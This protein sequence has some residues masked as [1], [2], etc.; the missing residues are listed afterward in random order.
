M[1]IKTHRYLGYSR[2]VLMELKTNQ[3]I[4][5]NDYKLIEQKL[6]S[7][8]PLIQAINTF[9]EKWDRFFK[10]CA[11]GHAKVL[12]DIVELS[13][14]H[15]VAIAEKQSQ[16]E[17]EHPQGAMKKSYIVIFLKA[18]GKFERIYGWLGAIEEAYPHAR[19]DELELI[20]EYMNAAIT[21]Q[22]RIPTTI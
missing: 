22:L 3:E 20:A 14:L 12:N 18:V 2:E 5:K 13:F 19:I 7:N 4:S 10:K 1:M 21:L 9:S 8:G 15:T 16:Q 6:C 11:D 17:I